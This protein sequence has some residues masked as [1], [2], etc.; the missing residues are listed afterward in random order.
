MSSCLEKGSAR[1]SQI[2]TNI[3][4]LQGQ[5][6]SK[7]SRISQQEQRLLH[8]TITSTDQQMKDL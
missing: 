7:F 5:L 2:N 1:I 4:L 3:Y 8:E 6:C